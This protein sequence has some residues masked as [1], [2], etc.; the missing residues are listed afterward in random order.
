[1][2]QIFRSSGAV[3]LPVAANPEQ[4]CGCIG[5]APFGYKHVAPPE[6]VFNREWGERGGALLLQIFRSSG[7][8][9]RPVAANPE[10]RC[11]GIWLLRFAANISLLR[12]FNSLYSAFSE[13]RCGE[14]GFCFSSVNMSLLRSCQIAHSLSRL[15]AHSPLVGERGP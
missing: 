5:V 15:F 13:Q 2:L 1:L 3:F 14:K 7:A 4:R 6:L 10:Q 9:F 11:G 8:V 12:S